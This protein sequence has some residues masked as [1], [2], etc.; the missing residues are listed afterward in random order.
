VTPR[1]RV[2][3]IGVANPTLSLEAL[4]DADLDT[5]VTAL[6][7][8]IDDTLVQERRPG[9][10]VRLSQA[11]LVC[12]AVAQALL[13]FHSEH[14]WSRFAI[15]HL[16]GCFPYL[17]HQPGYNKRLR[18]A[19]PLVKQVIRDLAAD[20][21]FWFDNVWIA[22]STPVECGRSRPTVQHSNMAGWANY[23][24]C[25][26][27]SR[28]FWGLRLY[29]ICTP[30]GMPILWALA[31]PKIGER[32]VLAAMLDVEP[33]LATARPGLT[34]I[35]DKGFAGRQT[36]ADLAARGTTLLRPARKDEAT[37]PSEPLL[38][39]IRQLIES[40]NDTLKGQLDLERHG[41]RTPAG[42]FTRIAQRLLALA[43]CIWHNWR[44]G[45]SDKRSLIAY[46]H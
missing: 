35:T 32:E 34:L 21:D 6:Y 41:G 30:A 27:H 40:V 18:A 23:G 10:P 42:I 39:T 20:S 19:L 25:K 26:S 44:I 16:R 12:L 8:K 28:W 36:K 46:D 43:A 2:P 22:D 14:R 9:H 37:R 7:V 3:K 15:C 5:L 33:Q 17:P 13:G 1:A 38:K 29:L 31:D 4:V 24:Y 11:E 45:A